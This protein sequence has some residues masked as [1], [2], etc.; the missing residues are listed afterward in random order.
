MLLN[1]ITKRTGMEP[2]CVFVRAGTIC[3]TFG[4]S[5]IR[6]CNATEC[7]KK[8]YPV[9]AFPSRSSPLFSPLLLLVT[10]TLFREIDYSRTRQLVSSPLRKENGSKNPLGL[11]CPTHKAQVPKE[12]LINA[13]SICGTS[14]TA[15][16]L[17]VI[18]QL[19]T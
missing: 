1:P 3:S 9:M 16:N 15:G 11:K 17:R 14:K 10:T 7:R 2:L 13:S 5:S 4:E 12:K 18:S 19:S 6:N 8:H